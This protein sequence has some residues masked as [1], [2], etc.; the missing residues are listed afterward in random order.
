MKEH[1]DTRLLCT[2]IETV[3]NT[4]IAKTYKYSSMW[5][6]WQNTWN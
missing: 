2:I 4:T 5:H 3:M 1:E 6:S